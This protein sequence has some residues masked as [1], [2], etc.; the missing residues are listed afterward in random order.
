M[1]IFLTN[2]RKCSMKALE[3]TVCMKSQSDRRA[4]F[5]IVD[6][7]QGYFTAKQAIDCGFSSKNHHYYLK[8]GEWIREGRGIYRLSNYPLADRPDLVYWSLWS[9]NRADH[10]QGVYS[11]ETVLAI[12]GLSDAMPAKLDMT[13]PR[14][15]RRST[16]IPR[17]LRLHRRNLF[18]EDVN[19]QEGYTVTTPLRTL[20]DIVEE[21]T[22]STD[23]IQ[24]GISQA[25]SRGLVSR[26]ELREHPYVQDH[27]GL[28]AKMRRYVD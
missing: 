2:I 6:A 8:R 14:G 11:H 19:H 16:S 26:R 18:S 1:A 9:R 5:E 17:I 20:I 10:P 4:L 7:Q 13:V 27:P 3:I 28:S 22:L 23:L 15:F 24:Q 25:L 21:D 12:Y